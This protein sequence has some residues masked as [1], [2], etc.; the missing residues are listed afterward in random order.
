MTI[1]RGIQAYPRK[2][3]D[4]PGKVFGRLTVLEYGPMGE[5]GAI[6]LVCRCVCG[7]VITATRSN[8]RLGKTN[9][10]GCLK[11]ERS[12]MA[13]LTHGQAGT[14]L[15]RVWHGMIS[16]CQDERATAYYKYG[17]KGVRVCARWRASFEHFLADMGPRPSSGHSLDRWPD[18]AGHYEPGNV[19][20]ATIHE[21]R[22]N[23]REDKTIEYQGRRQLLTDWTRELGLPFG[24][25]RQRLRVG[26]SVEQAFTVPLRPDRRRA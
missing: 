24:A 15:Y 5:D 10:C 1:S 11:S 21:Q 25:I 2:S 12:R 23:R 26:W 7:T 13:H 16:R 6:T 18:P 19:R 22:R 8:I 3:R 4:D 14:P 9:S 20:W 17:A